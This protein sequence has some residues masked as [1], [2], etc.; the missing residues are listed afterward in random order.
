MLSREKDKF[1]Q[2]LKNEIRAENDLRMQNQETDKKLKIRHEVRMNVKKRI[3]SN[4]YNRNILKENFS[5]IIK[6][7]KNKLN[8]LR[9]FIVIVNQ[10]L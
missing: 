6:D 3:Q 2:R 9:I 4:D 1:I 10:I 7:Y 5:S 8:F